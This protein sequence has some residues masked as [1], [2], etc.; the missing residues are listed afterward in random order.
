MLD[1]VAVMG[2]PDEIVAKYEEIGRAGVTIPILMLPFSCPLDL[3][4]KTVS[5]F[6]K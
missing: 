5:A 1:S 4:L 6:G 3:A 2:A